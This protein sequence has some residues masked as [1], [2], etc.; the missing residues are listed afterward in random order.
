MGYVDAA[1]AALGIP[2]AIDVRGRAL[3]ATVSPMPFVEHRYRR[4]SAG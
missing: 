2:L 3:P 4:R 1:H